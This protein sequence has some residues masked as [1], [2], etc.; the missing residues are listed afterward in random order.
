MN[1]DC[2]SPFLRCPLACRVYF[3]TQLSLVFAE[4]PPGLLSVFS[5]PTACP[6][7]PQSER[8]GGPP[9]LMMPYPLNLATLLTTA[10]VSCLN[11]FL[12]EDKH[13]SHPSLLTELGLFSLSPLQPST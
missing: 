3:S 12:S 6:C 13:P 4:A 9:V 7:P 5:P 1:A 8:P 11:A 2:T 10:L